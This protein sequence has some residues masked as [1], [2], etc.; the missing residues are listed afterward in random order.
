MSRTCPTCGYTEH[1][2]AHSCAEE[3]KK[4][5]DRLRGENEKWCQT[6]QAYMDSYEVAWKET[7]AKLFNR[8]ITEI[9][10]SDYEVDHLNK[11]QS[12]RDL[13]TNRRSASNG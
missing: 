3:L 2:G 1:Y 5:V 6:V 10:L 11:L 9:P 4:E 8:G 13:L 7:I 12:L